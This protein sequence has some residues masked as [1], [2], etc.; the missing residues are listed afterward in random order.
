MKSK[1]EIKGTEAY[2]EA[3]QKAGRDI[4]LVSRGALKEAGEILKADMISRVPID[5]GNLMRHIKIFTPSREGHFNYIVVG[6]IHDLDYTDER[7]AIQANAIE[8]GS[9]HA[10]AQPFIRPAIRAKRAAIM[11]LIRERL[12]AAKLVD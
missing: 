7:T 6:I 12:Q 3:L 2:L 5:T 9:V 8:F 1:F 11:R 4:D 10:A